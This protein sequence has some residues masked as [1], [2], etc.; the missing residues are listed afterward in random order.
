MNNDKSVLKNSLYFNLVFT[1]ET[2]L[3]NNQKE[4]YFINKKYLFFNCTEK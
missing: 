4:Y 1:L 2:V 3:I